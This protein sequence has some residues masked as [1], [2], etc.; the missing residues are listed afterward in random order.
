[1]DRTEQMEA[2]PV[3]LFA[4]HSELTFQRHSRLRASKINP[5]ER[6]QLSKSKN[7]LNHLCKTNEVIGFRA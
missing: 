3:G 1:M 5:K 4:W 6:F 2:V 7:G